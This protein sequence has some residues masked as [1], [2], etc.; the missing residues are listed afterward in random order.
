MLRTPCISD[1]VKYLG[2]NL[3]INS[4]FL[5]RFSKVQIFANNRFSTLLTVYIY[6]LKFNYFHSPLTKIIRLVQKIHKT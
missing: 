1:Q 2:P 6:K 4:L 3:N 5:T